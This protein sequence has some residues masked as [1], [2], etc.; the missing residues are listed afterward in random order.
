M[1]FPVL[2]EHLKQL[3]R[4]AGDE[5]DRKS[6]YLEWKYNFDT[7]ARYEYDLDSATLKLTDH[8]DYPI[9]VFDIIEIGTFSF[10][11]YTWKWAW[12]NESV[13]PSMR[14]RAEPLKAL[15]EITGNELF[16]RTDSFSVSSDLPRKFVALSVRHLAALCGFAAPHRDGQLLICLAMTGVRFAARPRLLS[17]WP[18]PTK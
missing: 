9:I 15:H 10:L 13:P 1:T 11:D 3:I 17:G 6:S 8:P 14:A 16:S 5:L 12:A 2:D 4:E 18:F 7:A